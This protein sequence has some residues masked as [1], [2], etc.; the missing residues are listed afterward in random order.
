[1]YTIDCEHL[2]TSVMNQESLK[3]AKI[4]DW[5]ITNYH[6]YS[7]ETTYS[8]LPYNP[9]CIMCS[10]RTNLSHLSYT[11]NRKK[12]CML[13][14][15]LQLVRLESPASVTMGTLTEGCTSPFIMT[16]GVSS[17]C[18]ASVKYRNNWLVNILIMQLSQSYTKL[19]THLHNC[20]HL[21][22]VQPLGMERENIKWYFWV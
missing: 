14:H 1:M 19:L 12:F 20:N 18:C 9:T 7:E 3:L 4:P 11:T 8:A 15:N 5:S 17:S 22:R 2:G 6:Q 21:G 16:A 13:G 10:K